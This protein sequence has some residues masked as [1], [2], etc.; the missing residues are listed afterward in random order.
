MR[1]LILDTTS[2]WCSLCLSD[3]A[4]IRDFRHVD[5][6]RGHAERL[7][8]LIAELPEG[9]QCDSIVVSRG[10]GSFTGVRIGIS[11]ARALSLAWGVPVSGYGALDALSAAA[12]SMHSSVANAS[13]VVIIPGGH[14]EYFAQSYGTLGL[15]LSPAGSFLPDDAITLFQES[16]FVGAAAKEFVALRGFG[17]AIAIDADARNAMFLGPDAFTPDMQPDYVRGADA[18]PNAS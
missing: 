10:P 18:K 15:T 3:G 16:I 2:N 11:A 5:L 14:G 17:T 6:G 4:D 8:P 9:G 1:R 12:R 13:H 7:I